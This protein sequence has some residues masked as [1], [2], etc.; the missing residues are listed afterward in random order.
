LDQHDSVLPVPQPVFV[1][2]ASLLALVWSK[3]AIHVSPV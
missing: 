2:G 3:T 1:P